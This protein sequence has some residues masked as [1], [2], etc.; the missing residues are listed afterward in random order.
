[1]GII[2]LFLFG[3]SLVLILIIRV[4][5][6]G[7]PEAFT[8]EKGV[9]VAGSISEK[10][11]VEING[12]RQGMFIRGKNLGNPVL[13]FLHGGPG[14]PTY[15]LSEKFPNGLEDNFV[16]C[17]WE[18]RGGG[19]SF[20][21]LLSG[22]EINTKQLVDDAIAVS[23]YL[24]KRFGK[25]KIYLLGHSWGS[26]IGIQTA[27]KSPGL[28]YAYIGV[29]QI[30]NQRESEKLAYSYMSDIC[31]KSGDFSLNRKLAKYPVL[32]SDDAVI[33]FFKSALRDEAMHKMGV[34][35]MR[36]MTSVVN[37]IFVPV[38]K[39]R[40]YTFREKINIWRAKSFLKNKTSLINELF[41]TDLM[42]KVP[43]VQIPVYFICGK[44][45]Y[46]VS[47]RLSKLY[48][49][50]IRAPRKGFYTFENSAH[51]PL[52]EET[53]LFSRILTNDILKGEINCADN[54]KLLGD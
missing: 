28:F 53:K 23:K 20:N 19:I 37:G 54:E 27:A 52:F 7:K 35:T 42:F 9:N 2:F 12:V 4:N 18:Q 44:Q 47:Y 8:D 1:M 29:S 43:E 17:Y 51:S 16:V 39:C 50:R 25:E 5:S 34:G 3:L 36:E 38:M 49:E 30:A 21:P 45:D 41:S 46:T 15:F 14:M 24:C 11:F 40:A 6:P 31:Q 26:F 33:P 22:D 10:I 13:L 48:F 32:S